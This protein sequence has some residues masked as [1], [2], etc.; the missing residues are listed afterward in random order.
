MNEWALLW[1]GE[2]TGVVV[3][4]CPQCEG[5]GGIQAF[6]AWALWDQRGHMQR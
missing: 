4:F 2:Q 1:A 6:P 5:C 3:V